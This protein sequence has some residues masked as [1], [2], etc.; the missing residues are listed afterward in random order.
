MTEQNLNFQVGNKVIHWAHGPGV[1]INLEEKELS[2]HIAQYY[3][4]QMPNLTLWVPVSVAGES[5]L[6]LPT[7]IGDF[8]KLF[9]ILTSPGED[10]PTDRL[11]RKTLLMERLKDGRLE[12]I[13]RVI[14]DLTLYSRSKKMNDHDSSTLERARSFLLSEW[15]LALSIPLQQ[16]GRELKE[17]LDARFPPVK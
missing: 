2:G 10:L 3:V 7:P 11:V 5:S 12:S 13:C 9:N 8:K 14:R 6:R 15:S 16:A 4:V 17:M 1:I